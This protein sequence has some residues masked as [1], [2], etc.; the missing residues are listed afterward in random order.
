MHCR[1]QISVLVLLASTRMMLAF[2]AR[3]QACST[4]NDISRPQPVSPPGLPTIT[5][6]KLQ[7]VKWKYDC[8]KCQVGFDVGVIEGVNQGDSHPLT[9]VGDLIE[10]IRGLKLDRQN[11]A[12]PA[13]YCDLLLILIGGLR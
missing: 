6:W 12:G 10:S 11:T 3:A 5:F 13:G 2:G 9:L 7:G 8:V 4:S 1:I